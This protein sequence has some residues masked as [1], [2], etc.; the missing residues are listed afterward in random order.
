MPSTILST[1]RLT[2]S[3]ST[4]MRRPWRVDSSDRFTPADSSPMVERTS[5]E[6][7][8]DLLHAIDGEPSVVIGPLGDLL[9]LADR[10]ARL[11]GRRCL[12]LSAAADLLDCA[13]QLVCGAGYF[14]N[15]RGQL[16]RRRRKGI[17]ASIRLRLCADIRCQPDQAFRRAVA[18]GQRGGLLFDAAQRLRRRRRLL[19]GRRGD[20]FRALL[21]LARRGLRF[22]RACRRRLAALR[23]APQHPCGF[24]RARG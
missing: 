13:H 21:G 14:L 3:R 22:L 6:H 24:H 15:G 20:D 23:R 19:L 10:G 8:D 2:A 1:L 9:D 4:I 12:L 16:L 18:F 11:L 5:A 17:R 7:G